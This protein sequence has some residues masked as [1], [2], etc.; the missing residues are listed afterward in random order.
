MKVK[1][2][3]ISNTVLLQALIVVLI[4]AATGITLFV[5]FQSYPDL[6]I[7][8]MEPGKDNSPEQIISE[9]S[10]DIG[11]V[12][13][14]FSDEFTP[15]P[16]SWP[17]FRGSE[18]NNINT[19]NISLSDNWGANGP[20][21][22]WQVSLGDGHAAPAVHKG[23]VYLLDYDQNR[24]MD[25]LRC[26]DLLTGRELW[27]TGYSNPIKRNH[28]WSRSIP[29]VTDSCVLSIGPQGHV[30]ALSPKDGTL[31]WGKDLE[32]EYKSEIPLWYAA[33]CPI[34]VNDT[35]L[36][37]VCS[38]D[39][40]IEAVDCLTGERLWVIPNE[41]NIKMSHASIMPA[42]ISGTEQFV[43]AGLGGIVGFTISGELLWTEP[44]EPAVVAPSPVQ[45][46]ENHIYFTAGYGVGSMLLKVSYS[47]GEWITEK[48]FTRLPKEGLACEQ[49]TP[50]LYKG[51]LYSIL[52][53]DAGPDRE[54][55]VKADLEGNIIWSSSADIRFGLGP[56]VFADNKFF[57][58]KEDATLYMIDADAD[59]WELL[60][61]A[62]IFDG[63][64]AWGPLA[65]SDGFLLLRDSHNMICLDLRED[66]Y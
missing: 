24:S 22:L 37:A 29:Y 1:G 10:A 57:I 62:K 35:V 63:T 8:V 65:I 46:D 43:Y 48:V 60:D 66:S 32:Q 11:S 28:G 40:L 34:I 20:I 9:V 6:E 33:Q 58:L 44:W 31:L 17:G 52:P 56:W 59:K 19:E 23:K 18:R 2:Y 50:I 38:D 26:F 36:I 14:F 21:Q 47:G 55:F 3:S 12:Y 4:T 16:G 41:L 15:L 39:V 25:L 27:Q 7:S 49:Q 45:T 30:M 64:D 5:W 61:S 51:K 54:K 53:K 42:S 13:R